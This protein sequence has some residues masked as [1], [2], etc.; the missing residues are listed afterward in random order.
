MKALYTEYFDGKRAR[1]RM[2]GYVRYWFIRKIEQK[3]FF[4]QGA[5][6]GPQEQQLS[7]L[8]KWNDGILEN[9]QKLQK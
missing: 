7:M 5:S 3:L 1:Y 2:E 8:R 4:L 9:P 6:N